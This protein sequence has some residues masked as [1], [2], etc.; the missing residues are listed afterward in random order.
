MEELD[1]ALL[2]RSVRRVGCP[3]TVGSETDRLLIS[4]D[5]VHAPGRRLE[6]RYQHIVHDDHQAFDRFEICFV[7]FVT[8]KRPYAR[9]NMHS[10]LKDSIEL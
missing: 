4:D 8:L 1:R 10:F 7:H 5:S 6:K 9:L 2:L 3:R